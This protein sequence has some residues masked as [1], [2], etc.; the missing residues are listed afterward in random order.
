MLLA[1]QLHKPI[2]GFAN[3]SYTTVAVTLIFSA[4]FV[5]VVAANVVWATFAWTADLGVSSLLRSDRRCPTCARSPVTP[6]AGWARSRL[7]GPSLLAT[8]NQIAHEKSD[9][10]SCPN[11]GPR[12]RMSV[13]IGSTIDDLSSRRERVALVTEPKARGFERM[14]DA[15][16]GGGK[17]L[18][19][20]VDRRVQQPLDITHDLS[21]IVP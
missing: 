16:T 15:G 2:D 1:G 14:L 10:R 4:Y 19:A 9:N 7:S 18:I 8:S 13:L 21:Q 17:P 6:S 3:S 5:T 12:V 11:H 20:D